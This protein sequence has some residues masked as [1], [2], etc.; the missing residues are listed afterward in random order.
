[1][2]K[3]DADVSFAPDY[4][5]RILRAFDDDDRL[6]IASGICLELEDGEWRARHV[7]RSHVRGATRAYRWT[8]LEEI[9]PL[10]ERLGWD[11]ID[12]IQAILRGW[13][14][15]TLDGLSFYHHR[16]M[17]ERDGSRGS[18]E[19]QGALAWYLGYRPSYLVVR[20][21]FRM[22]QDRS[23][24]GLLTG[25]ARAASRRDPRH[26]DLEVRRYLRKQQGLSRLPARAREA[27]GRHS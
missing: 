11:T 6:G 15:R 9:S 19:S 10:V 12:E 17:G 18:W 20:T 16:R 27:L 8:C 24:F 21:I 4:F 3:L 5:E 14:V 23:A 1:V 13:D 25:W 26:P 22:R 2:V 7:T